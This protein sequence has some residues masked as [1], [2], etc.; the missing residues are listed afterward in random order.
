MHENAGNERFGKSDVNGSYVPSAAL[1]NSL[2]NKITS[3]ID[4]LL[5]AN[6]KQ[7]GISLIP[8]EEYVHPRKTEKLTAAPKIPG[9]MQKSQ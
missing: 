1:Y 6:L 7:Q 2:Q 3:N 5:P 4:D 8:E 9:A